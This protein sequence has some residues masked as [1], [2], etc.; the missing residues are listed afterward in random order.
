MLVN[1]KEFLTVDLIMLVNSREY[2]VLCGV[3]YFF[4]LFCAFRYCCG[5]FVC[6]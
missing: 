5:L 4:F 6:F 2:P 3:L 1:A